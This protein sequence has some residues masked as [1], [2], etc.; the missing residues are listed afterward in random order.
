MPGEGIR[1]AG[2]HMGT[3]GWPE[4]RITV[5]GR[6]VRIHLAGILDRAGVQR[7]IRAATPILGERDFSV[8]LDGSRLRHLDYRCVAMLLRWRRS[9]R[10]YGH[11]LHLAGW[12][13]YLTAI[14][15]M[16]DWDGELEEGCRTMPQRLVRQSLRHI[17][18]P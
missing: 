10:S 14:L 3:R 7:L 5:Q 11:R 4:F 6:T 1:T 17:Q 15:A 16:E 18:V 8:T 12:N 9:L 13:G 2:G